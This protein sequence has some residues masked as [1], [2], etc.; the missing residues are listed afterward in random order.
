MDPIERLLSAVTTPAQ[1][2]GIEWNSRHDG[3][4]AAEI[5]A[6]LVVPD[7]YSRAAADPT[8]QLLYAVLGER[9]DTVVERA[10]VPLPDMQAAMRA[11][12]IDLFTLESRRPLRDFDL[13]LVVLAD[14]LRA[15]NLVTLLELASVPVASASRG[16]RDPWLVGLGPGALAAEPLVDF[17]DLFLPGEPELEIGRLLDAWRETRAGASRAES[18]A[19]MARELGSI[20]APS[21]YEP[22]S[23]LSGTTCFLRPLR[24]GVPERVSIPWVEDLD[25]APVPERPIV[26]FV[27]VDDEQ[28]DVEIQ[29][30]ADFDDLEGASALSEDRPPLRRRSPE[31]IVEICRGTLR[32]TGFSRVRL[33]GGTRPPYP[34]LS[35]LLERLNGMLLP[36]HTTIEIDPL[37]VA[38]WTRPVLRSLAAGYRGRA[39]IDIAAG[40][41][42]LRNLVG[43]PA[44]NRDIHDLVQEASAQLDLA[45]LELRV[46][47]G[48]PDETDDDLAALLALGAECIEI[49]RRAAGSRTKLRILVDAFLPRPFE[50]FERA[51]MPPWNE[52][53]R[54]FEYVRS[55]TASH[56]SVYHL[57][58]PDLAAI[59]ALLARGDRALGPAIVRAREE[60]AST[61]VLS[62]R[63]VTDP[64]KRALSASGIDPDAILARASPR[65][66]PLPWET[67]T[68]AAP[69]DP[70]ATARSADPTERA[71]SRREHA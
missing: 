6:A 2:L 53:A 27:Q 4:Q 14:E 52:L 10:F 11:A 50:R 45:S 55:A 22:V 69:E 35:P 26:G 63:P 15:P 51:A 59:R 46:R 13:V 56:A 47:I 39:A 8:L 24:P 68:F 54:R 44:A 71:A 9:R 31:R 40:S 5:A 62:D 41:E 42:R 33:R 58:D 34:D 12:G 37:P 1:Y 66:A 43:R 65:Y 16:T 20:Y 25:A 19:R 23:D 48:W 7:A 18:L 61:P 3:P 57:A 49:R 60:G 17:F 67:L 30:G 70:A 29:R 64:W 32:R 36:R 28:V 38:S 21:L